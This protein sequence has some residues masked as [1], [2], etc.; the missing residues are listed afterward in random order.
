MDRPAG[1]AHGRSRWFLGG[2]TGPGRRI[3]LVCLQRSC[4]NAFRRG[5]IG[6][7]RSTTGAVSG[8]LTL[9]HALVLTKPP[10]D[11]A[12]VEIG[13]DPVSGASWPVP[14]LRHMRRGAFSFDG[15]GPMNMFRTVS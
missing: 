11:A 7:L 4:S 14:Q 6:P 9:R 15:N 13:I 2:V 5:R 1:A 12:D 10:I 8:C 3:Q